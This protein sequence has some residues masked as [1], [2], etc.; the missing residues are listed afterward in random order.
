LRVDVLALL[1]NLLALLPDM[2]KHASGQL[3]SSSGT[4]TDEVLGAEFM[5]VEHVG[6]VQNPNKKEN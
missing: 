6:I 3:G 2:L 4:Q 5:H 1:G